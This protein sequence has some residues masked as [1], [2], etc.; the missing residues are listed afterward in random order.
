MTHTF[1]SV[2]VITMKHKLNNMKT[3]TKTLLA[4]TACAL[5]FVSCKKDDPVSNTVNTPSSVSNIHAALSNYA[6]DAQL[7]QVNAQFP[8]P[9]YSENGASYLFAENAFLLPNGNVAMGDVQI[10]ITE[11]FNN[12]DL[13]LAGMPTLTNGAQLATGGQFLVEAMQNNQPLSP[14]PQ[15]YLN[16]KIP[17]DDPDPLMELFVGEVD[18]EG[19]VNWQ[20]PQEGNLA[21]T[22]IFEENDSTAWCYTLCGN[23]PLAAGSTI[24][25]TYNSGN[26]AANF[27]NFSYEGNGVFDYIQ[28][29]TDFQTVSFTATDD[30]NFSICLYDLNADGWQGASMTIDV[31]GE[32]VELTIEGEGCEGLPFGYYYQLNTTTLGWINCDYSI[33]LGQTLDSYITAETPADVSCGELVSF[34][35]FPD[36]DGLGSSLCEAG[37]LTSL[38]MPANSNVVLCSITL[39]DGVYSSAFAS[40]TVNGET[41]VTLDYTETSIAEFEAYINGL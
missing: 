3:L 34:V 22:E 16:A 21:V 7:F 36:F 11:H 15:Y 38:N 5:A 10:K 23:V 32:S 31:D 9:I 24:T 4:F 17:T 26:E 13:F 8:T 25:M 18:S 39:I 2:S 33:W 35:V 19:N 30:A 14:S 28:D 6:P 29:M 40:A 20:S 12:S 41:S 27:H 1:I 37:T